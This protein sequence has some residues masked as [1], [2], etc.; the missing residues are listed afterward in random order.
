MYT[1]PSRPTA[2]PLGWP[3]SAAAAG[4]PSPHGEV[5]AAHFVPEVP[6]TIG[7]APSSMSWTVASS[8]PT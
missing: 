4:P 6:A 3:S 2:N 8:K 5:A 1:D 7:A